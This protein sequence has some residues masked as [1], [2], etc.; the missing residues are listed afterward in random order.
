ML[1]MLW[2]FA[3]PG[4]RQ[5][6]GT[7]TVP[8]LPAGQFSPAR[9][10]RLEWWAGDADTHPHVGVCKKIVKLRSGCS[11]DRRLT[12]LTVPPFERS[13]T[14]LRRLT[15]LRNRQSTIENW[16]WL[17]LCLLLAKG[18]SAGNDA[19]GGCIRRAARCRTSVGAER[20]ACAIEV[21]KLLGSSFIV[22][23]LRAPKTAVIDRRY[24]KG[25]AQ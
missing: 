15:G 11:A 19:A 6:H 22:A 9:P 4:H 16:Q 5:A 13:R 2:V 8:W 24:S 10:H 20:I 1:F 23:A 21:R 7:Q 14:A 12:L 25:S 3:V 17:T 18:T